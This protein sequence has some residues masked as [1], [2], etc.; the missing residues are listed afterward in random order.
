VHEQWQALPAPRCWF[1][2]GLVGNAVLAYRFY[3]YPALFEGP[4][5][6][7]QRPVLAVKGHLKPGALEPIGSPLEIATKPP[8]SPAHIQSQHTGF[9]QKSRTGRGE[10][11][12]MNRDGVCAPMLP[13]A[14]P[15]SPTPGSM[16]AVFP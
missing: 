10:T 5:V 2:G 3:D 12:N 4:A 9:R 15:R 6:T 1:A 16:R 13:S 8:F 11:A 14:A 7:L